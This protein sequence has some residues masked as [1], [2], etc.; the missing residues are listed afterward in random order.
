LPAGENKAAAESRQR[1][2]NT[3]AMQAAR[4]AGTMPGGLKRELDKINNP[5]PPWSEILRRHMTAYTTADYT[6]ARPNRRAASLPVIL[7]GMRTE[8]AGHIAIVVDT[9]GSID[10]ALLSEFVAQFE[11]I[12][13]EVNPET[14]SL[15]YCDTAV[16]GA[17]SFSRYE[18]VDIQPIG[19]GGT[20]FSP[21]LAHVAGM[22]DRPDVVL[23]FTDCGASD[24][25][26]FKNPAGVPILWLVYNSWPEDETEAARHGEVIKIA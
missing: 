18:P 2:I 1:A 24:W 15:I 10:R 14:V 17:R 5:P 4:R 21:A 23:Y 12:K 8:S 20:R 16:S 11:H 3:S 22:P 7:P 26:E 25:D 19:G 6:Y 9:S 13:S